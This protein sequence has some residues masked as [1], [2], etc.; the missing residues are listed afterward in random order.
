MFFLVK[1]GASSAEHGDSWLDTNDDGA[2]DDDAYAAYDMYGSERV[3]AGVSGWTHEQRRS[4]ATCWPL[5]LSLLL[6]VSLALLGMPGVAAHSGSHKHH[7]HTTSG[8][9][10]T[11]AGTQAKAAGQQ[12]LNVSS[13]IQ[14]TLNDIATNGY[15]PIKNGLWVNWSTGTQP[16]EVDFVAGKPTCLIS[17]GH[18]KCAFSPAHDVL[19]DLRYLHNLWTY[20][21]N[22]PGDHTYDV[23]VQLYTPIVLNEFADFQP[24]HQRLALRRVAQPRAA[25]RRQPLSESGA[26]RGEL[27]VYPLLP[28]QPRRGVLHQ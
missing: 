16:L 1:I 23:Q 3:S 5:L 17:Q 8:A 18:I 6:A 2:G 21:V 28:C 14:A 26:R 19:T 25:L 20:K 9:K 4:I 27:L 15:D 10:H 11:K 13:V 24:Q 7:L 12:T 22:H